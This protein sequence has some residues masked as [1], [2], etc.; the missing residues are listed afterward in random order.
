MITLKEL[1]DRKQQIR[2]LNP[3]S[4]IKTRM[5]ISAHILNWK[6]EKAKR[7]EIINE[8]L[9]KFTFELYNSPSDFLGIDNATIKVPAP[10]GSAGWKTWGLNKIESEVLKQHLL[11]SVNGK[12]PPLYI[13]NAERRRW[14]LNGP[15]Y[16]TWNHAVWWLKYNEV[17]EV[18]FNEI[19]EKAMERLDQIKNLPSNGGP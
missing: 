18:V 14:S 8:A 7:V 19:W 4:F 13:Y 5:D 12:R 11:N 6:T 15:D 1:T 2:D 16:P 17:T 9:C 10:W 3:A